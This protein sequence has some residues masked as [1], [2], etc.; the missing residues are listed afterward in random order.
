MSLGESKGGLPPDN[1]VEDE[2]F[3]LKDSQRVIERYHDA[4]PGSMTQIVLAPCSPF[5]VTPTLLT[6]TAALARRYKVKLHT[7]LCETLDEERLTLE[8]FQMRPVDWME[9]LDWLGDDVWF[10]HAI[11]VDDEEIGKF[12][13]PTR[14]GSP[15]STLSNGAT[16]PRTSALP[17]AASG[18]SIS[19]SSTRCSIRS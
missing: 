16:S 11:H 17:T 7:R 10:A 13:T 1:C 2:D 4:S 18:P 15:S 14:T 5:S 6:E 3:I 19:A 12:A 8:R 9:T